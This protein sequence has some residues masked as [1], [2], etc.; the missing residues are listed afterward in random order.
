MYYEVDN[1]ND[2][3]SLLDD[4]LSKTPE[5][6]LSPLEGILVDPPWEFYVADGKNDG[7]C[8]WNLSQFESLMSKVVRHMSAGM[9]FVWTHKMIQADVVRV[10]YNIG[11]FSLVCLYIGCLIFFVL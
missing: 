1:M 8:T 4:I 10:M 6:P 7:K 11:E 2:S 3:A 5:T 9:V